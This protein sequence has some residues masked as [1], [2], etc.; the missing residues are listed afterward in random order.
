[1][2]YVVFAAMATGV[3]KFACCQP[4]LVSLEN[5]TVASRAPFFVQRWP[6][7]VPLLPTPL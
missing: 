4:D 1:M 7:W 6:E 3:E 5:F 2:I